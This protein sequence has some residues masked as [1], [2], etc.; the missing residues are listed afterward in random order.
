M[1][2]KTETAWDHLATQIAAEASAAK[3]PWVRASSMPRFFACASSELETEAP[4][5]YPSQAAADGQAGHKAIEITANGATP[6]LVQ[7]AE[8]FQTDL[9][10]L[11]DAHANAVVIW[12]RIKQ[13]FPAGTQAEARLKCTITGGRADLVFGDGQTASIC[14]WKF[15]SI[16]R[17]HRAQVLAYA[18]ALAES[19][20]FPA[21]GQIDAW[22]A[23]P[24]LDIEA[25]HF[26]IM[27]E[28][29][30]EFRRRFVEQAGKIGAGGQYAP[31]DACRYCK[32]QCVCQAREDWIRAS[33][34]AIAATPGAELTAQQLGELY[35]QAKVLEKALTEYSKALRTALDSEGQIPTGD[36]K[37]L[38]LN[39]VSKVELDPRKAWPVLVGLGFSQDD[40]NAALKL[41]KTKVTKT[42]KD[43]APRGNKQSVVDEAMA[44]LERAGAVRR[45]RYLKIQPRIG[46]GLSKKYT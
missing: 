24:R 38:T 32:R 11:A 22:V 45:F 44:E 9:T 27:A 10:E 1:E 14:D 6:D 3:L 42:L 25:E 15:G 2:T 26:A 12:D 36:G 43:R 5:D 29:L 37:K 28:D 13:Y 33:G 39:E 7:I 19:R 16:R 17:D 8:D 21:S 40:I 31:G 30:I 4:I 35:P 46:R 34:N 23:Y 41:S 20:G 18:Y